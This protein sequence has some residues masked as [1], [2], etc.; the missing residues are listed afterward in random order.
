MHDRDR[1]EPID[2]VDRIDRMEHEGS[3]GSGKSQEVLVA[4]ASKGVDA[5][6]SRVGVDRRHCD[7]IDARIAGEHELERIIDAMP[8]GRRVILADEHLP[9]PLAEAV[10]RHGVERVPLRL[11]VRACLR[12]GHRRSV[13]GEWTSADDIAPLYPREPEAVRLWRE[14]HGVVADTPVAPP[15]IG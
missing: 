3:T 4:L 10:M 6:I 2:R 1:S 14:R 12:E 13:R 11:S 5:W 8:R 7:E 9:V 15:R